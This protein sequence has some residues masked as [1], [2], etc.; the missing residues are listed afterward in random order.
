M[1]TKSTIKKSMSKAMMTN[2]QFST[3]SSMIC[4]DAMTLSRDVLNRIFNA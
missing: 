3:L 4:N 1:A 2:E